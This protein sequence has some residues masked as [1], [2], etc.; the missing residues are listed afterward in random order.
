MGEAKENQ[1]RFV[2]RS[3]REPSPG[4]KPRLPNDTAA[5]GSRWDTFHSRHLIQDLL[6]S[7]GSSSEGWMR[8][9]KVQ[10]GG[11]MC[12]DSATARCRAE[13]GNDQ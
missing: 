2:E 10:P 11:K 6:Q 5:K 4:L 7:M 13:E 12:K 3:E 1:E 8:A 9:W